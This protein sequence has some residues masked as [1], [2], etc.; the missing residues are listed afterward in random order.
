MA[1][2]QFGNSVYTLNRVHG[3]HFSALSLISAH[4]FTA[5]TSSLI[6]CLPTA[7]RLLWTLPP[8]FSFLL[9]PHLPLFFPFLALPSDMASGNISGPAE[10]N[11]VLFGGQL[12]F[13]HGGYHGTAVRK[14]SRTRP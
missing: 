6:W 5:V 12:H 3:L 8:S 7:H 10:S 2:C 4:C 14:T 11:V 9:P 13:H 1:L